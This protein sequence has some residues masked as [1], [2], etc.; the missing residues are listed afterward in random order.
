MAPLFHLSVN[1]CY[2]HHSPCRIYLLPS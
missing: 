2:R 1:F